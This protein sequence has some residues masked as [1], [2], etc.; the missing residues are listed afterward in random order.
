MIELKQQ[1]SEYDYKRA[2]SVH[3]KT[4]R[5]SKARPFLATALI[6]VGVWATYKTDQF[7]YGFACIA[8]GVF[9]LFRKHL[10]IRRLVTSVKTSKSFGENIEI[11]VQDDGMFLTNQG[12]ESA[13][14]HL[15]N[16]AGYVRTD[17]GIMLYPQRNTFFLLKASAFE[18]P[19]QMDTL[20]N[21]LRTLG[22]KEI[23]A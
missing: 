15:E 2:A 11:R 13:N 6:L 3:F 20:E 12:S 1:L 4:Y 17:I 18:D 16:L 19:E 5:M 10:W 14:L 22:V 7:A 8:Y 9:M 21:L 23:A